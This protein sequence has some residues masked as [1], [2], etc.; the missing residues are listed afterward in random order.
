MIEDAT[1][2]TTT[3]T[4]PAPGADHSTTIGAQR[5]RVLR[6]DFK[7]SRRVARALAI[8][9]DLGLS[10]GSVTL[11]I[12]PKLEPVI[13]QVVGIVMRSETDFSAAIWPDQETMCV[14][15]ENGVLDPYLADA[16]PGSLRLLL[17][18]ND[19]LMTLS[20]PF[21]RRQTEPR[22]APPNYSRAAVDMFAAVEAQALR[23]GATDVDANRAAWNS[24]KHFSERGAR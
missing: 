14:V 20:V 8:A 18:K 24:I 22:P 16:E 15:V 10:P 17:G 5:M 23:D 12:A 9:G 13:A 4:A 6:D 2:T 3:T 7:S 1:T 21:E 19:Q 11:V